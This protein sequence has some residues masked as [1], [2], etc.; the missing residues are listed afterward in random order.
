MAKRQFNYIRAMQEIKGKVNF[1]YRNQTNET[2]ST[3]RKAAIKRAW[4]DLQGLK[5]TTIIKPPKK[6]G[7]AKSTYLKRI[8]K[9]K[10]QYG[11]GG[12]HLNGVAVSVPPGGKASFKGGK[13]VIKKKDSSYYEW[14][15]PTD[16]IE[17]I[18]DSRQVIEDILIEHK[19]DAIVPFHTHW[20]GNR[21]YMVFY[22]DSSEFQETVDDIAFD[23]ESLLN[24]Y[25]GNVNVMT[26][27]LLQFNL[28]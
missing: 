20:R 18:S 27:F 2:L 28:E 4:N 12:N 23:V 24:R 17:L 8:R 10:R 13:V 6:K 26:G 5:T 9:I 11:Q 7:E 15:I 25:A 21:G 3:G 1:N 16:P 19:P 14:V 22:D